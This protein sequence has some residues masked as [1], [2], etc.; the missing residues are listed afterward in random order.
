MKIFPRKIQLNTL[1]ISPRDFKYAQ[2][3]IS[4]V[5]DG[6]T[7]PFSTSSVFTPM[8]LSG[9]IQWIDFADASSIIL[10]ISGGISAANDKSGNGNSLYQVTVARQPTYIT[11]SNQLKADA[12]INNKN[13]MHQTVAAAEYLVFSRTTPTIRP[14]NYTLAIVQKPAGTNN[15]VGFQGLYVNAA[16]ST[17]DTGFGHTGYST[18]NK[19]LSWTDNYLNNF[20]L[21]DLGNWPLSTAFDVISTYNSSS[22]NLYFTGS[23]IGTDTFTTNINHGTTTLSGSLGVYLSA[24]ESPVAAGTGSYAEILLYNRALSTTELSQLHSYLKTKWAL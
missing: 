3:S 14:N 7:I 12:R 18:V 23:L 10:G 22:V 2:H 15:T 20:V 16:T 1:K 17:W 8:T 5:R 6:L 24:N 4:T 21:N 13:V 9:L 11:A 19:L